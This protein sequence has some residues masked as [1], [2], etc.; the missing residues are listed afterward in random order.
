MALLAEAD[1]EAAVD[2]F[3]QTLELVPQWAAGWFSLAEAF[4]KSDQTTQAID[5]F[6]TCL[7]LSPSDPLGA[8]IRL[9]RLGWFDGFGSVD[10]VGSAEGVDSWHHKNAA[11]T[12]A[13]VS[14]LFDQY[15]ERFDDHLTRVL[16]YRGPD[17][18]T[19][20]LEAACASHH[21][22]FHFAAAL[23]LGCGTGL[24]AK[25]I[26]QNIGFI[27]GVDLSPAMVSL[28]RKTNVYRTA[29][30][31]DMMSALQ[32]NQQAYDLIV[33]ADVFV[34]MGELA[35]LFSAAKLALTKD[36]LFAFTIQSCDGDSFKLGDDLRYHHSETY[37]GKIA[38]LA[39][40][41]VTS[42]EPCITRH[43]AGKPALG[44]VVVLSHADSAH[45]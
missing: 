25:A 8:G 34:Y 41:T 35:L 7:M 16:E 15:A 45:D 10:G 19:S 9:E 40:L 12:P 14:A 20:A 2:L 18:I 42:L 29:F 6:K 30:A 36:G 22:R 27:D 33:A 24:M 37:I 1:H 39:G 44:F 26:A 5:A 32:D 11:M 28:A 3:K 13:Y 4:E 21:R 23:D 31:G 43:D 17:I 38:A